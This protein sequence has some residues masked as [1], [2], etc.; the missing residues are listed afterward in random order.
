[1]LFSQRHIYI[2]EISYKK[3]PVKLT[4]NNSHKICHTCLL[5][6]QYI[7]F[8]K[9]FISQYINTWNAERKGVRLKYII[10]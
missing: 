7:L 5:I 3:S 1:M 9:G 2:D 8:A 6:Y 4:G 10:M